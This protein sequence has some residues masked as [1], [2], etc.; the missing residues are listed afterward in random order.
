MGS[1]TGLVVVLLVAL[2]VLCEGLMFSQML[3]R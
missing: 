3:A 1:N 2:A